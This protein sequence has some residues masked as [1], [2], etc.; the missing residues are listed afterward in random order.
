MTRLLP[1]AIGGLALTVIGVSAT[2]AL[3][4]NGTE[5]P[6]TPSTTV[7]VVVPE[8]RMDTTAVRVATAPGG[9]TLSPLGTLP[10]S[11]RPTSVTMTA[12]PPLKAADLPG[13][14]AE[15]G[16]EIRWGET[17]CDATT[18]SVE[19]GDFD[20][21]AVA[22]P[23][24]TGTTTEAPL[25][26]GRRTCARLASSLS[27]NELVQR[28]A[29]RTVLART[30]W[31]SVAPAP[32]SWSST[33]TTKALLTV[34]LPAPT[35]AP[36]PCRPSGRGATIGWSWPAATSR[37]VKGAKGIARWAVLARPAGSSRGW[38]HVGWAPAGS[39]TQKLTVAALRKAGSG[40]GAYDLLVRAYPHADSA[41]VY[42]DSDRRWG[43][44]TSGGRLAC[45][46]TAANPAPALR[47]GDGR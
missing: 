46:K 26:Q 35:E 19:P 40:A 37:P 14:L 2:Q 17:G 44:T 10:V 39:R 45:T 11:V 42:A 7:Q 16:V 3:G 24:P 25:G 47:L 15:V 41:E 27:K 36:E 21:R 31:E 30:Q 4:V 8:I 43:V 29:G 9:S 28:F 12:Q 38:T 1:L 33:A 13:L 34:P 20:K 18:W 22:A 6:A 32:V 23:K 5:L